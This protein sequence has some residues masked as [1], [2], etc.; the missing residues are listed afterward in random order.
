MSDGGDLETW[1]SQ[2][3]KCKQLAE[4]DV[5]KLCEKV[6]FYWSMAKRTLAKRTW[7]NWML[8]V[9]WNF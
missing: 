8:K 3:M 7:T 1:I 2:L 9:S 4:N 5:K 6:C